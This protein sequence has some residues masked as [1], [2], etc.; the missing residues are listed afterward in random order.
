MKR[1]GRIFLL[2]IIVAIVLSG[3]VMRTVDELYCLPKRSR[4]D[5]DMQ[6]VIDKAMTGLIYCAPV[7]GEN[8]QMVQ[9]A[10][11]DGDGVDEYVVLAKGG[12]LRQ[13]KLLIFGQYALGYELTDTIESYGSAF[14]F[15]EF[16][17]VDNQPGDEII[18]GRQVGDGVARSAAVYHFEGGVTQQLLEVS[19]VKFLT[20][21][22]NADG[23]SELIT[24]HPGETGDVFSTAMLYRYENNA[25]QRISQLN[26][27]ASADHIKRI[28]PV[29][30]QDKTLA[31]LVVAEES[32]SQLMEIVSL[33]GGQLSHVYG[34]A[35][36]NKL[37][38]N[39]IYPMDSD[40]DGDVELPELVSMNGYED[41][42][43]EESWVLWFG[44]DSNGKRT[45][46][47]YTYYSYENKWYIHLN[48]T[49]VDQLTVTRAEGICTFYNS[50]EEVVMTVYA[51]TGANRKEQAQQLGGVVLGSS[52]T[53]TFA[54]TIGSAAPGL[55][56]TEHRVKQ[57]FYGLNLALH[58]EEE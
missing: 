54:A 22:L 2:T 10:D 50:N 28:E 46:G 24:I 25:V 58:T 4:S 6:A 33:Q 21:D 13:L 40:G 35:V 52:D 36:V 41:T 9:P 27:S 32:E 42:M 29:V 19:Y 20:K 7:Y 1:F 8:R 45:D 57:M 15:I 39:F 47:M 43:D 31:I 5:N 56:I 18:V 53:I 48:R 17:N 37:R 49:W 23:R 51:L 44:V 16:A 14:D 38:D 55:D 26:I 11:L 12:S 34:P 3:C 30:L